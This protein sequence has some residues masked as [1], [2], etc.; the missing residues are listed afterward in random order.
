LLVTGTK[1]KKHVKNCSTK[2]RTFTGG[3]SSDSERV[4]IE[5]GCFEWAIEIH[6][7]EF[8]FGGPVP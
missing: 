3:F 6:C 1:E 2:I 5:G 4:W 7:A 8:S